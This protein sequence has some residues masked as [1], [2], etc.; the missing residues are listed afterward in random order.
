ME[1]ETKTEALIVLKPHAI[2]EVSTLHAETNPAAVYLARLGSKSRRVQANA[3]ER[4]VST[5][6]P[7]TKAA[8][9]DVLSF[10][11]GEMRYQ[12]VQAVMTELRES[13]LAATTVNRTL[14]ALKGVLQEAWRLGLMNSEDYHRAIDV[15]SVKSTRLPAGRALTRGELSALF[16][17]CSEDPRPT[18]RRDAAL[19]ALL[20]GAGL[21]RA[22]AAALDLVGFDQAAGTV[23]VRSGKGNKDRLVPMASGAVMAVV[24][25]LEIRGKAPGPVLMPIDKGGRID[26]RRMSDQAIFYRLAMLAIAASV[27]PFTPHDLR[28][29]YVSE[30]LD[31]GADM[32]SVSKMAGHAKMD[33]TR[34]YDRRGDAANRKAADLLH[35]PY[36][37]P[38]KEK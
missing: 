9:V 7:G 13:S 12:Y 24:A 36:V 19:I 18:G 31:A 4:I 32:G 25:W 22:E 17:A 8:I 21:R 29:T 11:W 38:R 15:K 27:R 10:P 16:Y 3:L 14:S 34:I 35:V 6:K 28:R 5:L 37:P 30:L 26:H 20:F 23:L 2:S 33:T 1:S